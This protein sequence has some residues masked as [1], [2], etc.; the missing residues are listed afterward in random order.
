[1]TYNFGDSFDLYAVPADAINGYWDSSGSIGGL[2]LVAGRFTGSRALQ[3]NALAAANLI[4]ASSVNDAVHHLVC[5]AETTSTLTGATLGVTMTLFD[6]ATPQCSVVFRSDGAILLTSGLG[7]GTVLATYTGALTAQ[8]TWYGFE[9]EIVINATTGSF[10]VRKN[11]NSVNDFTATG[12]NTQNSANAY[13]NKM[14]VGGGAGNANFVIDDLFWRSGAATGSWLGDIRCLTRMPASDQSV[15][16]SRVP[17]TN[18]LIQNNPS[19]TVGA[20]TGANTI[21]AC[22][23][24]APMN[25]ALT[26]LVCQLNAGVTGHVKMALYDATALNGNAGNLLASSAE[27]LNPSAGLN[28]FTVTGGPIVLRGTTY[29]IAVW[30]DVNITFIG[31]GSINLGIA[32]NSG[33]SVNLT[34][35]TSFPSSFGAPTTSS[36]SGLG[37]GGMNIAATNSGCV[38]DPQQDGLTTYVYDSNP[39]DQDF[40]GIA[41]AATSTPF[42]TVATITR[43]YMQ[44]SDAGSRTAAVSLKSGATTVASPT[45]TLSASGFQWASRLDLVDP[46]T[47]AVWTAAAVAAL[48]VGPTVVA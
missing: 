5:S 11:G 7:T 19:A 48:Q 1:M 42:S 43:A 21:R 44:K 38:A 16:F 24:V 12:L 41:A 2:N 3:P 10:A 32:V 39:G 36:V 17:T 37:C 20:L 22:P 31:N 13:A 29:W 23:V 9:F 6:G 33:N 14:Q 28:T 46:N 34:Y 18:S 26:S 40:Y 45:L 4:K 8:T 47:S 30:T 35:T 15:A 25:G 27:L